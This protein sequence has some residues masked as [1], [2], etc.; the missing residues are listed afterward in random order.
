LYDFWLDHYLFSNPELSLWLSLNFAAEPD[1]QQNI[2]FIPD[3]QAS[4]HPK[5]GLF[6]QIGFSM[7]PRVNLG[8]KYIWV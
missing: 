4:R 5:L 2:S 7:T 6:F 1:K 8:A 3:I